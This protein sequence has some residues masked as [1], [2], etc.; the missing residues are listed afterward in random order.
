MASDELETVAEEAEEGVEALESAFE[1]DSF[2]E[3]AETAEDLWEV[4]DEGEDLLDEV[5]VTDLPDVID[6]EDLPKA[7]NG[8]DIP[9]AIANADPGKAIDL[10]GLIRAVELRELWDSTD[11]REAWREGREF[12]DA[13]DEFAGD[14]GSG[15]D[16]ILDLDLDADD[17]DAE[18]LDADVQS[19]LYESKIQSQL[20]GSVEQFREKLLDARERLQDTREENESRGGPGQPNSRNPTAY[21]TVPR[22]RADIGSSTRFSTVPKETRY[23]SAPNFDR[24]YGNRFD[25]GG[26]DDE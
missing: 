18:D 4:L 22:S 25:D 16:G 19:E 10:S 20:A 17:L 12:S 1:S 11:V 13:L 8:E 15:D 26:D 2:E 7:I 14:D 5:D 23:S 24:V 6:V 21:S 3:V 9:E